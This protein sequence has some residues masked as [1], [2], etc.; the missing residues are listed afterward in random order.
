MDELTLFIC[1]DCNSV[2]SMPIIVAACYG[3]PKKL[4]KKGKRFST[5]VIA[6]GYCQVCADRGDNPSV[7]MK[8]DL[9]LEE[10]VECIKRGLPLMQIEKG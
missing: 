1:P 6:F 4:I 5:F 3:D 7:R 10:W 9:T 2:L 8:I